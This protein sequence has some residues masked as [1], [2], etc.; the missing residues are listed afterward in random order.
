MNLIS[1]QLKLCFG[2]FR[3]FFCHI[4]KSGRIQEIKRTIND[5]PILSQS[6]TESVTQIF[7]SSTLFSPA[8]QKALF[9]SVKKKVRYQTQTKTTY[10]MVI[11]RNKWSVKTKGARSKK[12]KLKTDWETFPLEKT[13]T[14]WWCGSKVKEKKVFITLKTFWLRED[15]QWLWPPSNI[16]LKVC[17]AQKVLFIHIII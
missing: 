12:K 4:R 13:I 6:G 16:N 11:T 17:C 3:D 15:F 1:K 5:T 7:G 8:I 9:Q 14:L 10:D 2:S